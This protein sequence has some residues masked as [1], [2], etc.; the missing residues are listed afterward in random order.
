MTNKF[1][2]DISKE[3]KID[4]IVSYKYKNNIDHYDNWILNDNNRLMETY[5]EKIILVVISNEWELTTHLSVIKDLFYTI[6]HI[7]ILNTYIKFKI[8][9][10]L[11]CMNKNRRNI[12]YRN[13]K[14]I[15]LLK[16]FEININLGGYKIEFNKNVVKVCFDQK[17][18]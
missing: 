3:E 5:N 15:D 1:F 9:R 7:S 4:F 12:Y 14:N 17:L 6:S 11:A 13:S 8:T 10:Y 16:Q 2:Y 18:M